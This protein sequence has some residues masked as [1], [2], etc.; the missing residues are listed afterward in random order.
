MSEEDG[1][2]GTG[3]NAAV[4]DTEGNAK[5]RHRYVFYRAHAG[6]YFFRNILWL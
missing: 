6:A 2:F 1:S 5:L 4:R 3:L